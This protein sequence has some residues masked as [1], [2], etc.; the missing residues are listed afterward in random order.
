MTSFHVVVNLPRVL[1]AVETGVGLIDALQGFSRYEVVKKIVPARILEVILA[2]PP[3]MAQHRVNFGLASNK[4]RI[5]KGNNIT[6][7]HFA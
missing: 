7:I 2:S 6:K 5:I 4:N 1:V 3:P